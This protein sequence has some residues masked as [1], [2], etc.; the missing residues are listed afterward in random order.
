MKKM[1]HIIALLLCLALILCLCACGGKTAETPAPSAQT[2]E[3]DTAEPGPSSAAGPETLEEQEAPA[4]TEPSFVLDTAAYDAA[5]QAVRDEFIQVTLDGIENFDEEAHPELPWYTA[6]LTRYDVNSYFDGFY[7]FDGNGVPEMMVALGNEYV[8][9]KT[10]IAVY[11]FDGQSMRYLCKECALGER[12]YLSYKNGLFIV[13][14]S[15]G[16]ASGIL[17]IYRIAADGWNT[18]VIDEISYEFTDAEHVTFTSRDGAISPEQVENLGLMESLGLDVEVE[19][20]Q[21]YPEA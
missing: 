12:S 18:E 6:V 13:H 4:E 10:V 1:N 14:G 9:E 2:S 7:D 11:A 5:A 19:W 8:P 21:F 3:A 20:V 16:A 15:G 17:E